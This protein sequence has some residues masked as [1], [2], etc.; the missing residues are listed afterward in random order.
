MVSRILKILGFY[1]KHNIGD[2]A[3]KLVFPKL[4]NNQLQFTDKDNADILGGG[5]VLTHHYLSQI[6]QPICALSVTA[7]EDI[8][9]YKHLIKHVIVRDFQSL[10][11]LNEQG[12]I[13]SYC[14]DIT[15]LLQP[16]NNRYLLEK[17]F[18]QDKR[19]LYQKV[20]CVVLNSHLF[21][22]GKTSTEDFINVEKVLIDLAKI[23]D[24]TNASFIFLPFCTSMPVDDRIINSY[25]SLKLKYWQKTI[26]VYDRLNVQDTLNIINSCDAVISTRLHSSIFSCICQK[27]FLDITHNHKNKYFL[28]TIERQNWS[29]NIEEFNFNNGKKLLDSLIDIPNDV[30]LNIIRNQIFKEMADVCVL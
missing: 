7:S 6:K 29:I 10:K 17:Y 22:R 12:I 16:N 1:N 26:I 11:F 15:F 25:V 4:F 8:S 27:P 19:D 18:K 14:P 9:K 3:Y 24:N 28:E 5:D 23:M 13:T 2:E 20:I 21:L 30:N